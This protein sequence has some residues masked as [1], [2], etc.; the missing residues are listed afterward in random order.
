[1]REYRI[2][3]IKLLEEL[4]TERQTG[5]PINVMILTPI[6]NSIEKI[7]EEMKT[8]TNISVPNCQLSPYSQCRP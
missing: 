8:K 4:S 5:R 3:V 6:N 7:L 1:M 2:G